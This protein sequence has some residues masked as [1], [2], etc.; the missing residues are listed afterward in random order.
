MR[1]APSTRKNGGNAMLFA[2]AFGIVGFQV[3]GGLSWFLTIICCFG[4]V[5]QWIAPT[6]T[7]DSSQLALIAGL[8]AVGGLFCFWIAR[9]I[10]AAAEQ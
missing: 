1:Q 5:R 4:I 7:L 8:A 3:I 10:R 6:D 2:P 9:K